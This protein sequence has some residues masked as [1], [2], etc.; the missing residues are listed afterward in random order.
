VA[1]MSYPHIEL[2]AQGVPYLSGTRTKV[3][4]VV[5]DR[6][7]HHWDA[8]EMQRQHPHLSLAQI[9]SALA[10][11]YDHQTEMDKAIEADLRS[12]QAIRATQGESPVRAILRS[13]GLLP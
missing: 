13:K 1:D 8:E 6:L 7:A 5:L 10:Y 9:Y 11:Y 12:V 3:I 4:E 2:D